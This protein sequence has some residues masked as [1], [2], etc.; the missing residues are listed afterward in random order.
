ME[1][2]YIQKT[3]ANYFYMKQKLCAYKF[4]EDKSITHLIHDFNQF[5]DDLQS[6]D[7]AKLDYEDKARIV[8]NALLE[9][10]E[11]LNDDMFYGN[12]YGICLEEVHATLKTKEL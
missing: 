10:Y 1:I 12:G 4:D 11:Q 8:L 2:L 3:M 6:I 5:V 9:S 7:D